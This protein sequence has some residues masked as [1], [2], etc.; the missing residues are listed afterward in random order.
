MLMPIVNLTTQKPKTNVE[1]T[2]TTNVTETRAKTLS[3]TLSKCP[4][5]LTTS[6]TST[7]VEVDM[8]MA[9]KELIKQKQAHSQ[10]MY[11]Q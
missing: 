4:N 3:Q 10:M 7:N 1:S 6:L 5:A 9:N 8:D 2:P 11:N